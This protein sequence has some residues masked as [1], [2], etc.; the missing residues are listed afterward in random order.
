MNIE[1]L[2]WDETRG[3]EGSREGGPLRSPQLVLLFAS[4]SLIADTRMTQALEQRY[5]GAQ[6]VGCSTAGEIAGTQVQEDSAVATAVE[7]ERTTVAIKFA[8]LS[9]PDSSRATGVELGRSLIGPD[10]AHVLVF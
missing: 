2:R 4:P 6:V 9:G 1:Q 5:P 8:T 7:F 10:L 3:W